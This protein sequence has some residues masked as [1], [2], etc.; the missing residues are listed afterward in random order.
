MK[1]V[2]SALVLGMALSTGFMAEA[3]SI[4]TNM[5]P[6][7]T[8][9][10]KR[11]NC[12]LSPNGQQKGWIDPG[13]YVIVQKIQNGWAY[14]SY[15]VGR[16][17][18]SRW[19]R[20]DDLVYNT[21]FTNQQRYSP[22]QNTYTYKDPNRKGI[23]GSFNNNETLTVVSDYGEQRQFI[24]K[25]NSG[26]Y[27]MAWAPYW[28][29]WTAEQ[30]GKV[31][32]TFVS[33][34]TKASSLIGDP[35]AEKVKNRIWWMKSNL[36]GYKDGSK[37]TGSGECRGFANNVYTYLFPGVSRISGYT[38]DNFGATYYNGSQVA[39]RLTGFGANDSAAIKAFF[40]KAKPGYFIQMG[41]RYSLNSKKDAAKPHSAILASVTANGCY[42]YEANADN[43]NT[44]KY[45]WYTWGQLA[46][47]N[48]GYTLYAP[49]N[50]QLK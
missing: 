48:R 3:G 49:N 8:Y 25:L 2:L 28:D 15:P 19:F 23:F 36:N 7:Q 11:V 26:G 14:G 13:D 21:R 35:M 31:T 29:C 24:Y 16:N 45:N 43:K 5:V 20:A 46:D 27:K 1:K 22:K 17:R 42:F 33:G 50:Y 47:R 40:T 38:G 30:A 39:A 34:V 41:R 10:I 6:L 4:P 32:S 37:Y 18:V 44:I 9:A 12:Y